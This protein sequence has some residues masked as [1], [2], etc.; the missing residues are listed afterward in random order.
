MDTNKNKINPIKII[1]NVISNHIIT[2][3]MEF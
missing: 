1:K 3:F 2:R